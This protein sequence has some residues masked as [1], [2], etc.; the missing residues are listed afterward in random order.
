MLSSKMNRYHN[1]RKRK[2]N[3]KKFVFHFYRKYRGKLSKE[4]LDKEMEKYF[5][6]NE[7]KEKEGTSVETNKKEEEN[8]T[9]KKPEITENKKE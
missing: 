7:K 2:F 9:E 8:N 4:K 1:F 5:D 3:N 6:K